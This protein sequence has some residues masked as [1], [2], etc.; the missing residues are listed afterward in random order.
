[1]RANFQWTRIA[2]VLFAAAL[3]NLSSA[4]PAASFIAHRG[5]AGG[6]NPA[7]LYVH[8]D[9]AATTSSIAGDQP[10]KDLLFEWDYGDPASGN[11]ATNGL[12]RNRSLGITGAHIY[13]NPGTY[14]VKLTVTDS[15]GAKST[16][17]RTVTVTDPNAVWGATTAC[18]S[19]SGNFSGCPSG[20]AQV[21]SGDF[22]GSMNARVNAGSRR[23]LFRRGETFVA[24]SCWGTPTNLRTEALVSAFGTGAQPIIQIGAGNSD[25]AIRPQGSSVNSATSAGW[26]FV[27]LRITSASPTSGA[28]GFKTSYIFDELM[29]YKMDIGPTG[30]GFN[31]GPDQSGL[32]VPHKY[33]ALV[34]TQLRGNTGTP[35]VDPGSCYFG[36]ASHQFISGVV[37]GQ[38]NAWQMRIA[39]THKAVISNIVVQKHAGAF[40]AIK[41]HCSGGTV[42]SSGLACSN[43]V[44]SDNVIAEEHVNLG[45]GSQENQA[46]MDQSVFERNVVPSGFSTIHPND[47]YR[48]NVTSGLEL[49]QR[50]SPLD[51]VEPRNNVFEQ[52]TCDR[53]GGSISQNCVYIAPGVNKFDGL[54]LRNNLAFRPAGAVAFFNNASGKTGT[55]TN[56]TN[57]MMTTSPF[58]SA[59]PNPLVRTDFALRQDATT[60]IDKGAATPFLELD[61]LGHL[62]P[63]GAGPDVGA[64]EFENGGPVV[65]DAPPAPPVLLS[66]DVQ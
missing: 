51:A 34:D 60:L 3:P 13:E 46:V 65:V 28:W 1:M 59:N 47:V 63:Q 40:E 4:A 18:V 49:R 24:N 16:T 61:L 22:T 43:M 42:Q 35:T 48:F 30:L 12:P 38:A 19:S 58:V 17:Q 37:C 50:Q 31:F 64:V 5:T 20:A 52:N 62:A 6:T 7:P 39:F 53:R 54:V 2:A 26:R 14:T 8:F 55:V 10:W 21:T 29:V 66:V 11:W 9:A 57:V 36:G 56:T 15:A 25:C 32:N 45:S 23:I 44:F 33:Y 27:D 41:F